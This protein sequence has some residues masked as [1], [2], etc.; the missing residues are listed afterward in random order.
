MSGLDRYMR[1]LRLFGAAKSEWTVQEMADRLG[2]PAS[3]VYRSVRDL[4]AADLL[5]PANEAQ[6]RLGAAFIE[7][8]R[9]IRL[10]D[11]L[12]RAANP[13]LRDLSLQAGLPC[14][15]FLARLYGDTV[16]CVADD[17]PRD[18]GIVTSYERGRP[19]PLTRGA[20]SKAI[21]A[22]LP[23][24]RLGKILLLAQKADAKDPFRQPLEDFRA[25]LATVRKRGYCITRGEVDKGLVGIA[26]PVAV[27]DQGINAS[28]TL[29]VDAAQLDDRTE[30]RLVML[31]VSATGLLTDLLMERDS[32]QRGVRTAG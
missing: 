19:M 1:L 23:A 26:A 30:R 15:V 9:L 25:Q 5:E 7:F 11:P 22:Q 28:L 3:T 16:M 4:V 14:A 31:I 17:R 21:L 20:T 27:P 10:T 13:L 12:M 6:Y 2:A 29:V 18:A 8:E 24:R 32:A